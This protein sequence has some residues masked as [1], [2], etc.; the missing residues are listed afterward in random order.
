[1]NVEDALKKIG[2]ITEKALE[3]IYIY[4]MFDDK[5]KIPPKIKLKMIKFYIMAL[6]KM[7]EIEKVD[8]DPSKIK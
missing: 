8:I 7:S 3:N 1:M 6:P 5:F 4:E 2:Q